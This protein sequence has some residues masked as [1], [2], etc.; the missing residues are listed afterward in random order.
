[1]SFLALPTELL[2]EICTSPVLEI[3][4]IASVLRTC[5]R[6]ANISKSTLI[7]QALKR[8]SNEYCTRALY[9]TA[10]RRDHF[11]VR[12]L[13]E[14]GVLE[15]IN[16]GP[17][18]L[19]AAVCTLG[20][21]ALTTLLECGV[22]PNT[23]DW[24]GRTPLICAT[25]GRFGSAVR[26]LL[27]DARVNVNHPWVRGWAPIHGAVA[28]HDYRILRTLLRH[29]RVD[30]NV[31]SM[32]GETP[33]SM[34]VRHRNP[35]AVLLLL[36]RPKTQIYLGIQPILHY[37]IIYAAKDIIEVLLEGERI[38]VNLVDGDGRTALHIAASIGRIDAIQLLLARSDID[39][40]RLDERG[41]SAR[42]LALSDFPE[43]ARCFTVDEIAGDKGMEYLDLA[44]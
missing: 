22:D 15:I 26:V 41:L 10:E 38:D 32:E 3:P 20:D 16:V 24:Q 40:E 37:A 29:A 12:L 17:A 34:S 21:K 2:L 42:D 5:R 11:T 31:L 13:L 25:A 7:S 19:N 18:L 8:R 6:L 30:V 43:A 4:D 33:L 39:P 44:I 14:R 27:G 35:L 36:A 28:R 9:H 23:L 1:M